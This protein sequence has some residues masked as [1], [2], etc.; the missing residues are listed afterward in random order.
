MASYPTTL[1]RDYRR[2]LRRRVAAVE[3]VLLD[4]FS[5][6][7]IFAGVEIDARVR[8]DSQASD[9][10]QARRII[11]RVRTA[12]DAANPYEKDDALARQTFERAK[13]YTGREVTRKYKG[14]VGVEP[15]ITADTRGLAEG[16]VQ[17]NVALIRDLP[18][19]QLAQIEAEVIAAIARGER[20][21]ALSKIIR[22]RSGVAK[23][24]ADLIARDQ[25]GKA[26]SQLNQK[27]QQDL[28]VDRYIWRTAGDERVR[29]E[30]VARNGE[31]F[32]WS[33]SP[34]DGHPGEPIN[35]RC[36]AEPVLTDIL[37]GLG[38]DYDAKD[39]NRPDDPRSIRKAR[40][41]FNILADVKAFLSID[42]NDISS[43]KAIFP[44]EKLERLEKAL[45]KIDVPV[46]SGEEGGRFAK[47]MGGQAVY[48]PGESGRPGFNAWGN[49]VPRTAVI[50]ELIHLRQH[51]RMKYQMPT[52]RQIIK[53]EIEAQDE[54]LRLGKKLNWSGN[55]LEPIR[56]AK[57]IWTK[58]LEGLDED[59]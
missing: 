23:K 25:M 50:E 21:G 20:A 2:A 38:V 33:D 4:Q 5:E 13:G 37:D 48:F 41:N 46:L 58:E 52:S 53:L 54:L 43:D 32:S 29:P 47:Q 22:E 31:T 40:T 17:E 56:Q 55:E 14:A 18:N 36:T 16:F 49:D 45:S 35:C 3:R 10:A 8:T 30:H 15:L 1:E 11:R 59:A 27:R 6:W 42:D 9:A 26:V 7:L 39:F 19:K 34:P 12:Y 24:R 51:R 44:P 57:G 28:G